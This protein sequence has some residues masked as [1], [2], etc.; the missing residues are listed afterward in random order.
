MIGQI[1]VDQFQGG[2][3]A[4]GGH[5]PKSAVG[6]DDLIQDRAT[7]ITQ[8]QA[9]RRVGEAPLKRALRRWIEL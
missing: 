8:P 9:I 2:P 7:G 1:G 5:G 3:V 4:I 6:V